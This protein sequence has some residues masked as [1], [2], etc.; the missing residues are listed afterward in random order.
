MAVTEEEMMLLELMR[1]KRAAMQNNS[2]QEGYRLA[3][4][5]EQD[6]LSKR[7]QSAHNSVSK[8]LEER[9]NADSRIS[10]PNNPAEAV[11]R[12]A[13]RKE[14]PPTNRYSVIQRLPNVAKGYN[15]DRYLAMNPPQ[16]D[17]PLS[18]NADSEAEAQEEPREGRYVAKMARMERFLMMKPSLA[19]AIHQERPVSGTE[20]ETDTMTATEDEDAPSPM[21]RLAGMGRDDLR[22][23]SLPVDDD[24][25]EDDMLEE[26]D[27]GYDEHHDKVRAFLQSSKPSASAGLTALPQM[28]S[29]EHSEGEEDE[30]DLLSPPMLEDDQPTP[31]VQEQR[32][33]ALLTPES[34]EPNVARSPSVESEHPLPQPVSKF[35]DRSRLDDVPGSAPTELPSSRHR[36][37]SISTGVASP[38]SQSF[39]N[40]TSDKPLAEV[41]RSP[42]YANAPY[43]ATTAKRISKVPNRIDTTGGKTI[44][45][46]TSMSSMTSAG[47]DVLAAWAELGGGSDALAA[48]RRGR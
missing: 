43:I 10:P 19:D 28:D 12:N 35:Q 1:K 37:P 24:D 14:P 4:K 16:E 3:L 13:E 34:R 26:S 30:A 29:D 5:Q 2:F 27:V 38:L 44:G 11:P 36:P 8:L 39:S 23:T 47:E 7:R 42:S 48:R 21:A 17:P 46:I 20:I 41:S 40:S 18:P 33:P 25:E 45:R 6:F 31:R 22:V 32:I 15:I 9:G